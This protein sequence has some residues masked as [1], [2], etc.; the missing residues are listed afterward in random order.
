MQKEAINYNYIFLVLLIIKQ[1]FEPFA[2]CK[3]C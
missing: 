3:S 2:K 1:N